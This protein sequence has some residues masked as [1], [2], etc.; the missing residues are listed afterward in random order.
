MYHSVISQDNHTLPYRKR[1][2]ERGCQ[3]QISAEGNECHEM[4]IRGNMGVMS[5]AGV[6]IT[7]YSVD[8]LM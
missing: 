7:N 5:T 3:S 2:R 1:K 6:H 8:S 4:W